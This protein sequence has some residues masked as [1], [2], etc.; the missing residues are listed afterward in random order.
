A[1][2]PSL[3]RQLLQHQPLALQRRI[4][5][6]F[7]SHYLIHQVNFEDVERF[8]KLLDAPNRSQSEPF[9]GNVVA[10]I[11]HPWIYLRKGDNASSR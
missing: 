6:Q 7:L 11:E 8:L 10:V 1:H 3:Q 4:I 5:R 9:K 2:Q